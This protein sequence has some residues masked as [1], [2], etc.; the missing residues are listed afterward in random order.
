MFGI[1]IY[2]FTTRSQSQDFSSSVRLY[3]KSYCTTIGVG[4]GGGVGGDQ[5]FK[6]HNVLW[7]GKGAVMQAILYADR[8]WSYTMCSLF[9]TAKKVFEIRAVFSNAYR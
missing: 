7:D 3:R 1:R 4:T 9:F 2:Q 6:Y 5:M 8:S